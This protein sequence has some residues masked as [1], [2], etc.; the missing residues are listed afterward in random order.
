MTAVYSALAGQPRG[1]VGHAFEP[2]R[3]VIQLPFAQKP[4]VKP[5]VAAPAAGGA[6]WRWTARTKGKRLEQ[7]QVGLSMGLPMT[8]LDLWEIRAP[9]SF[10]SRLRDQ[11]GR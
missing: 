3:H 1:A 9:G 2:G 4:V 5:G 7:S 10:Y 8:C 11:P 6:G